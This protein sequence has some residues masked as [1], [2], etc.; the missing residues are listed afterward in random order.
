MEGANK[1]YYKR[2]AKWGMLF[3]KS[4]VCNPGQ[5]SLRELEHNS[6]SMCITT[7]VLKISAIILKIHNPSP[8][9]FPTQYN[10]ERSKK[11]CLDGFD[12]VRGVGTCSASSPRI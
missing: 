12:N 4:G 5:K 10:V 1:V 7:T 11:L 6:S 9:P 8:S 2:C 3:A